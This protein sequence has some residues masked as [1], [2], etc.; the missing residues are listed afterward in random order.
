[1][2][3]CLGSL[4][5]HRGG[6]AP[7]TPCRS[8]GAPVLKRYRFTGGSA[9]RA[10]CWRRR[11]RIAGDEHRRNAIPKNRDR[12][13]A[14]YPPLI[15]AGFLYGGLAAAYHRH[16]QRPESRAD[17]KHR[18][19][20]A[21]LLVQEFGNGAGILTVD[22]ST[23]KVVGRSPRCL[24]V[25]PGGWRSG[26]VDA[27]GF[28]AATNVPGLILDLDR[29]FP[30]LGHQIDEGMALAIDGEIYQDAYLAPLA[31]DSEIYLVPKIGGG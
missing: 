3:R 22:P 14:R 30:G 5:L 4:L 20:F 21:P 6:L 17:Q 29:C 25:Q 19:E 18:T 16:R 9:M 11:A 10:L 23:G 13:M 7:P 28:T 27:V 15:G 26:R 31:P 2:R 1:M 24:G 12:G 8:P